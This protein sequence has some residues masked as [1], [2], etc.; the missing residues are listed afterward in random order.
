MKLFIVKGP[1]LTKTHFYPVP[2]YLAGFCGGLNTNTY[3]CK[4]RVC[5]YIYV[6]T[7]THVCLQ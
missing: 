7:H 5:V 1:V 3:I 6:H 2:F 4:K